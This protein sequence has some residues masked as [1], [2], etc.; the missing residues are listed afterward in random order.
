M[1]HVVT[2]TTEENEI[3]ETKSYSR[4]TNLALSESNVIFTYFINPYPA[5]VENR[6]SS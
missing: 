6:V 5:N 2:K 3:T 1:C 4:K